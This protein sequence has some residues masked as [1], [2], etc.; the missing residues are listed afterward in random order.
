MGFNG[1]QPGS[2]QFHPVH[3]D[4]MISYTSCLVVVSNVNDPHQQEF[5]RGHNEAITCLAIS[6]SGN[7][8]ASGQA[9]TTRVPNSEAMV[10]VWDFATRMPLFKMLELHDGIQFSRNVVKQLAF[11]PDDCF[12]AGSDD[13]PGGAKLC[14]WDTSTAQL[15]LI[16]KTKEREL[17]FIT[18]GD[19]TASTRKI[20]K[21]PSYGLMIGSKDKVH[22]HTLE[23]DHKTMQYTMSGVPM[24]LPSSG[25]AR[26]YNCARYLGNGFLVAG[27]SAGELCVFNLATE[28]FRACVPVS[29]GGLLS[30]ALGPP[31]NAGE[32]PLAYCGCGD[33]V[34][35]LL[36][37]WDLQWVCLREGKV[38][39]AVR[40]LTLSADGRE[41]LAGTSTGYIYRLDAATL[42][43]LDFQAN[44]SDTPLLASHPCPITC[45]A[46]GA[47]SEWFLTASESG[48]MRRWEL[49]MYKVEYEIKPPMKTTDASNITRAECLVIRQ[50]RE[51]SGEFALSGWTDGTVRAY[52]TAN[53]SFLWEIVGAHRGGVSCVDLSPLYLITGGVDGSVRVWSDA[54]SRSLVGTFDEH[55]QR[56]TGVCVDLHDPSKVHSCSE[57]KTLVTVCLNQARR[58]GSHTVKEGHL[59]TMCQ[60]TT[61]ELELVTGDTAGQLKWWDCD[62]AEP[63]SMMVTWSP[64]DDINKERRLTHVALSPPLEPGTVG[65]DYLIACTASGDLQVWDMAPPEH[66]HPLVSVGQAHSEE[67]TQACWTPDGRQIVSVGK[68]ACICVWNFYGTAKGR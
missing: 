39:G 4:V 50:E 20:N 40:S 53:G 2:V 38:H 61:G 30:L 12:L 27:S 44:A 37:G 25:L 32:P 8:I 68:D 29:K 21:K 15:A 49:S 7:L 64:H 55:R 16:Q 13:Q 18:W 51:Q 43:N 17:A 65:S 34:V 33:G 47:S 62:E 54:A 31:P 36:Q 1:E 35:K 60:A 23:F 42:D 58:V 48:A 66:Q 9:S 22:R 14:V 10:I 26:S 45:V 5:L 6:P 52:S 56:V 46:F 19:V 11:S 3:T 63:V 57:D 67:I 59:K 28:V 41:I 24:Q